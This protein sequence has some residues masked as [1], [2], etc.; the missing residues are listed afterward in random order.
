MRRW[1]VPLTVLGLGGISAF[2]LSERGRTKL[3]AISKRFQQAPD[4]LLE[5]NDSL[6]SDLDHIQAA[7]DRIADSLDP[8][9]EPGH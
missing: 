7:L 5:L 3:R 4:R 9:P 1:Y 8:H 2:L 6:Q